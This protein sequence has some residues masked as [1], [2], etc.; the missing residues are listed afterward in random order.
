M[1]ID[2]YSA[3]AAL[4]IGG[5]NGMINVGFRRA[6]VLVCSTLTLYSL[7]GFRIEQVLQHTYSGC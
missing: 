6:S 7:D 5:S 3:L 2:G 4:E 1:Q